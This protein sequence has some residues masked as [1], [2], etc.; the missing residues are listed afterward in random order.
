MCIISNSVGEKN[1]IDHKN[2]N[3]KSVRDL[4]PT[5]Q[6]SETENDHA[7]ITANNTF[8]FL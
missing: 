2:E 6:E 5:L 3:Q 8:H 4:G 1:H 7:A